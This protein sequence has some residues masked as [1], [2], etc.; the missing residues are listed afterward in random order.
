[1]SFKKCFSTVACMDADFE[2]VIAACKKY[3]I[4]GVEV[5]LGNDGSVFGMTEYT[6]IKRIKDEFEK[7]G[8]VITDLG[9]SVCLMGYDEQSV[10]DMQPVIDKAAEI[11][12]RGVRVFL[13]NF[14]VRVNSDKPEP[15]Y[16]GIV[17]ALAEICDDAKKKN[18]EIWVETHNEFATGKVLKRLLQDVNRENLKI[19]WDVIHPIEDGETIEETWAQIGKSIAHVHIKDGV[20]RHDPEWHDFQYTRLGEGELPLYEL[21]DLLKNAGYDGYVSL[22]WESAWR[23]ELQA[24]PQ[25]LDYILKQY[26]D[27]LESYRRK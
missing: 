14:A 5:R 9:S 27:F 16:R 20:N 8:I 13:G 7:S 25:D 12:C 21:L 2:T 10:K 24:F 18:V 26:N 22:E 3:H 1:M 17:K 4:A 11:G 6:D 15:D 19:I 23:P